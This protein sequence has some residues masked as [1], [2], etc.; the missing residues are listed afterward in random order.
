[1]P[2]DENHRLDHRAEDSTE[3]W[4]EPQSYTLGMSVKQ[5]VALTY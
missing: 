4:H 5:G 3:H 2:Q 1:M